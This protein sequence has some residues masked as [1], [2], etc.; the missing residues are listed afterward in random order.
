MEKIE[1]KVNIGGKDIKFSSGTLAGQ[2]DGAVVVESEG[3]SV[4]ATCVVSKE[5]S[6]LNYMPLM[7][8]YEERFYASGKISGSRFIKREGRPSEQAVLTSRLI[9]RPLRPLFPKDLRHEVQVI[10]TVLS[11]DRK[12]DPDILAMLAASSAVMQSSAPFAGPVGS[13]RVVLVEGKLVVNPTC[14]EAEGSELD[15]V[16]AGTEDRILMIEAR[17]NEVSEEKVIEAI[18][19]ASPFIRESI[20]AQEPFVAKSRL[21]VESA[22]AD[23]EVA[24]TKQIGSRLRDI[25]AKAEEGEKELALEELRDEVLSVFEGQYKQAELEE[26]FDSFTQKEVRKVII[27]DGIRPDGRKIDEIRPIDVKVGV[28]SRTHGSGLFTRGQT[29]ALTVATLASPGM[30]Q[31]IDTMEAETTKRYMH[32]YNFPP[33]C[34]GEVQRLKG[35]SRREIGHGALAEKALLPVL[36]SREDFAY[37]IRLVTE[38]LSSNGSSSMAATCGSTLALMDAGVPIK[39]PVAGIAMGM[40]SQ[41]KDSSD[42]IFEGAEED[43]KY[44]FAILTDLQGLED[45]GGDM[46]FKVAG[47]KDGITAIQLDVKIDGLSMAMIKST[48]AKA[49][50]GR[51]FILDKMNGAISAPRQQLSVYAPRIITVKINPSKIGELIGPGGKNIQQ[52]IADCGGK[53]VVAVDIEDDGTVL[54]SSVD[55]AAAQKAQEI[56]TGQ[57][58]SPELNK[59]YDGEVVSIQKDR[60]SGKE[61][62]AI[63]EFMSGKDGMV[64]ISEVSD[65]RIDKVSDEL[66]IGQKVKVKVVSIDEDR[67]RVGLSIKKAQGDMTPPILTERQK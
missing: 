55:A 11:Y 62:G 67:G 53:E 43:E 13:V 54:I 52:I 23:I 26:V 16:L 63:V 60:N 56:I 31:F 64:H 44:K 38:V 50:V 30:E 35:V 57:T 45:F 27:S 25:L 36:P 28:L 66:K 14:D 48:L 6:E 3:T 21:S 2:A 22:F 24:V 18:E 33:F 10:V 12:A 39:S 1:N 8:D 59:I 32:F 47:S 15:L 61:I 42:K 19:F 58:A 29:Q 40:V 17:S 7:V 46:D 41:K 37:T 20:K 4:L 34:T 5:P 9:D 49:K 51:M 65:R